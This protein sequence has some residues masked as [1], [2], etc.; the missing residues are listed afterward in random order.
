MFDG[1]KQF[2]ARVFFRFQVASLGPG[3]YAM[4]RRGRRWRMRKERLR[5]LM[6]RREVWLRICMRWRLNWKSRWRRGIG[7]FNVSRGR[8]GSRL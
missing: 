7:G 1:L 3:H 6:K 4:N 5:K 2:E 8:W